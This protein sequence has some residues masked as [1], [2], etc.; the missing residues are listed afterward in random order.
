M[1]RFVFHVKESRFCPTDN[2]EPTKDFKE[3]CDSRRFVFY[4]YNSGRG[5][6]GR[7]W[8]HRRYRFQLED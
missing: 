4:K 6:D 3:R 5:W 8:R 2:R 7:D 1:K